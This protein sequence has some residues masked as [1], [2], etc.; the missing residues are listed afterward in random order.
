[1]WEDD[2]ELR[3][4]PVAA[5]MKRERR[6]SRRRRFMRSIPV[7]MMTGMGLMGLKGC[8]WAFDNE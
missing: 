8:K 4:V 5:Q 3:Y 2:G 7:H 1:M 6:D